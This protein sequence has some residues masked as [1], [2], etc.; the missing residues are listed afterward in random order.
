VFHLQGDLIDPAHLSACKDMLST[1]STN[2]LIYAGMDGWRRQMVQQGHELLSATLELADDVRQ[3]ITK[4]P[5]LHVLHDELVGAEASH[6]LDP[7]K[8]IVDLTG[9]GMETIRVVA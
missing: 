7:L 6:D 2:V 1:T 5:G 9:L 4:I 8:V 3:R